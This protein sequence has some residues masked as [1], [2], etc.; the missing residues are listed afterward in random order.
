MVICLV[1]V[2]F[3]VNVPLN[4]KRIGLSKLNEKFKIGVDDTLR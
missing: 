3:L 2:C 4:G 1:A